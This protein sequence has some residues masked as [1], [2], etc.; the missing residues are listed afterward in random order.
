[1]QKCVNAKGNCFEGDNVSENLFC[2]YND[3]LDQSR[4]F[5]CPAFYELFPI[6]IVLDTYFEW[7]NIAHS[8]GI[9]VF[10]NCKP[11]LEAIK[12]GETHLSLKKSSFFCSPLRQWQNPAPFSESRSILIPRKMSWPT[13]LQKKPEQLC[14]QLSQ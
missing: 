5:V 10:S 6:R 7:R 3:L 4:F 1:M 13:I 2:K 12:R 9:I 14:L 8:D 11:T